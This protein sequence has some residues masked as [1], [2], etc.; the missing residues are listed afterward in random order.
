MLD[1][2][3]KYMSET[4]EAPSAIIDDTPQVQPAEQKGL[5][6]ESLKQSLSLFSGNI[7]VRLPENFT[8]TEE[9]G[10]QLI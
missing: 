4:T 3:S 9:E 2:V 10:K 6:L 5:G 8:G 1:L 7:A